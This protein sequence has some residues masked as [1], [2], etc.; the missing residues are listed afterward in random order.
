MYTA[1]PGDNKGGKEIIQGPPNVKEP[2]F[3]NGGHGKGDPVAETIAAGE[4]VPQGGI[5]F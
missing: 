4:Q 1:E 3:I 2:G 5:F